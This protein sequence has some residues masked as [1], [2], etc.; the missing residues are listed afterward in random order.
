MTMA[1]MEMNE[2]EGQVTS[3][4]FVVVFTIVFF[5]DRLA[6]LSVVVASFYDS[7]YF[8]TIST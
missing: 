2:E 7:K 4:V 6:L 3:H 8:D 5:K 1:I